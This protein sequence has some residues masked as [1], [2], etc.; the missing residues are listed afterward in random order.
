MTAPFTPT[1]TIPLGGLPTWPAPDPSASAATTLA[2]GLEVALRERRGDWASVRAADGRGG[3]VDGRLLLP[4]SPPPAGASGATDL[5]SLLE[6]VS[7]NDLLAGVVAVAVSAIAGAVLWPLLGLPAR[8]IGALVPAGDCTSRQPGSTAM[9]ICSAGVGLLQ[10][11]APIVLIAIGVVFRRPLIA[12]LAQLARRVPA[13]GRFLAAPVLSTGLFTMVYADIHR[14]TAGDSGLVPQRVFP[15]VIGLVVFAL[16]RWGPSLA[17]RGRRLLERRDSLPGWTRLL[18]AL[19]VPIVAAFL[20]NNQ[21]RVYMSA[22]NEQLV[23]LLTVAT[24]ALAL[25]PRSGDLG[26][27]RWNL[28]GGWARALMRGGVGGVL[29]EAAERIPHREGGPRP[30][31]PAPPPDRPTDVPRAATSPR[32]GVGLARTDGAADPASAASRWAP[33]HRVTHGGAECRETPAPTAPVTATLDAG[34]EVRVVERRG[35][36]AC[37][38]CSN[39]WSAWVDGRLLEPA[40]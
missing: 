4:I 19:G 1:H 2:A 16:G 40:E 10:L 15:A 5:D 26:D 13:N 22:R 27:V 14:D 38:L 11:A 37:I 23:I 36:W 9:W 18:L 17:A 12:R 31:R 28:G 32:V 3:W 29:D 30:A 33:S 34:L 39:A 25:F 21:E 8:L 35:E 24:S 20:L 6:Q 7:R